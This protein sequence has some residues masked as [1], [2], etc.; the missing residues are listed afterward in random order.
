MQLD[1]VAARVADQDAVNR[2]LAEELA[3]EKQRRHEDR[4]QYERLARQNEMTPRRSRHS[5]ASSFASDSGFESEADTASSCSRPITPTSPHAHNY[6][7]NDRW[8]T[9]ME[10]IKEVR[11]VSRDSETAR[12]PGRTC[13]VD[14]GVWMFMREEKSRLER[15]VQEL[16][17]VLDGCLD[18]IA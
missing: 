2:A 1:E 3:A 8:G 6:N 13:E 4:E 12:M 9:V 18:L 14:A 17:G 11:P 15:R 5:G 7:L 10:P 16:E